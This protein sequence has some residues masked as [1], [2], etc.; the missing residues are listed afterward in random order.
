MRID[1][2]GL[3][4]DDAGTADPET[5]ARVGRATRR[6]DLAQLRAS[7]ARAFGETWTGPRTVRTPDAPTGQR[8]EPDA[9]LL[10]STPSALGEAHSVRSTTQAPPAPVPFPNP[11]PHA[12]RAGVAARGPVPRSSLSPPLRTGA[13]R[14]AMA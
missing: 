2:H 3:P 7:L 1:P 4:L 10:R 9:D 12:A 5:S 6:L 13:L 8:F 14:R 11:P